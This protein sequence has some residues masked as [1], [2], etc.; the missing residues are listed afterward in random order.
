MPSFIYFC[1]CRISEACVPKE[2]IRAVSA[3]ID[4]AFLHHQPSS[5]A[6]RPWLT[7]N[8]TVHNSSVRLSPLSNARTL[9]KDPQVICAQHPRTKKLHSDRQ[10]FRS[11]IAVKYLPQDHSRPIFCNVKAKV[12]QRRTATRFPAIQTTPLSISTCD[13]YYIDMHNQ[14]LR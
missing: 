4:C 5:F 6:Q 2:R 8:A 13:I 12:R 3:A 14:E 1:C 9:L 11:P 10:S 7:G